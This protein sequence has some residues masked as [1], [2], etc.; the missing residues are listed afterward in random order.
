VWALAS[1]CACP[2]INAIIWHIHFAELPGE[3]QNQHQTGHRLA[4]GELTQTI[5]YTHCDNELSALTRALA[6]LQQGAY[7]AEIQRWVK[8]HTTKIT[9]R[10][11]VIERFDE[12]AS[13]LMAKLVPST[14]AQTSCLYVL[15]KGSGTQRAVLELSNSNAFSEH[16]EARCKQLLPLLAINL[17]ILSRNH[18]GRDLL[19]QTGHLQKIHT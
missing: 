15:D 8:S 10:V 7:G 6:H 9:K 1:A 14:G 4:S 5:P 3:A 16:E 13:S 12:I 18:L 2:R 19:L 11:Q 17:A